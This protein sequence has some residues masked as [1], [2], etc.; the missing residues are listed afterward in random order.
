MSRLDWIIVALYLA[1]STALGL[2]VARRGAL[3]AWERLVGEPPKL[4]A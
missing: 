4:N 2:V 1:G 3:A